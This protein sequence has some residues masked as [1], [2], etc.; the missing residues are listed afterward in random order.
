M[1]IVNA[2]RAT[3]N[4]LIC[5][6][7][8]RSVLVRSTQIDSYFMNAGSLCKASN[9]AA[10]LCILHQVLMKSSSGTISAERCGLLSPIT[11]ALEI[12]DCNAIMLLR[13]HMFVLRGCDDSAMKSCDKRSIGHGDEE[14]P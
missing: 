13:V 7:G 6:I 14:F 3:R 5:S 11:I 8:D 2:S 10:F 1:L 12:S 4:F 9:E